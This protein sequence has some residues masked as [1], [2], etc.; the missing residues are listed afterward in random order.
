MS[1]MDKLRKALKDE[2]LDSA[3]MM[4]REN[5][6]YFTGFSGTLG[7]LFVNENDAFLMVD[8]RYV[9]QA[10]EEATDCVVLQVDCP[11]QFGEYLAKET[12][13]GLEWESLTYGLYRE[14][15]SFYKGEVGDCGKIAS[16]LRL[17]KDADELEKIK[18]AAEIA[19][20]AFHHILSFLKEGVLE[21]EISL[22]LEFFMRREGAT[23]PSFDFIVAFGDRSALP[24]GVAGDQALAPG[25]IV[26]MDFG[27][28]YRHYCSDMTR[29]V[30]FGKGDEKLYRLYDIVLE[31]QMRAIESA[32]P[33]GS[34][35]LPDEAVRSYFRE[36]NLNQ[37]F[38]HGLGHGVGLEIHED[39]IVNGRATGTF[40][41]GMVFTIEPGIYLP[42]LGGVRI[43]DMAYMTETGIEILTRSDKH[44]LII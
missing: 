16:A 40:A 4:K 8:S 12:R 35:R 32:V 7:G 2:K 3:F 43:E 36:K 14:I 38:G 31:G 6:L 5:L 19:D 34:M 44:R 25:Q 20:R 21:R 33:G 42:G 10:N 17:Y 39:P 23:G 41:P 9:E 1:R 24:H 26:L 37:Y 29:T 18:T 28:V 22:E 30:F 11:W 27:C 13:L 15:T